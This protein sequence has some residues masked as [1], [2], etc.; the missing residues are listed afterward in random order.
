MSTSAPIIVMI[1]NGQVQIPLAD[2][3][4]DFI[5]TDYVTSGMV[6]AL[7][8]LLERR[9]KPVYQIGTSDTNPCSA[10]RFGELTG[11]Y[12]RKHYQRKG[13]G[14]PFVNILQAHIEAVAV[15][16]SRFDAMSSPAMATFG[17]G[18]AGVLR[19]TAPFLKPAA[20]AIESA[21]KREE[22]IG[23]I[24]KLFAPFTARPNGPFECT[25]TRAA[26][27]RLGAED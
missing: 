25:N 21:A 16:E 13:S 5:P 14:N 1:M 26:L 9:A 3:P 4:L 6:V 17:R 15:T 8:E 10:A 23:A 24:M 27:A 19:K 18:L 7:G 20:Q 11:L 12:K 2:V 22:K